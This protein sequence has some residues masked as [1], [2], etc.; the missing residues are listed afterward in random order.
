LYNRFI[1]LFN[2]PINKPHRL[3]WVIFLADWLLYTDICWNLCGGPNGYY[4]DGIIIFFLLSSVSPY[5]ITRKI[6]YLW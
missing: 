3:V 4:G 5:F 2:V 1:D 6:G